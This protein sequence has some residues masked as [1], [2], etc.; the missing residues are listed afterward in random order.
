[1]EDRLSGHIDLYHN[2]NV[3]ERVTETVNGYGHG[4]EFQR[5]NTALKTLDGFNGIH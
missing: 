3:L 4:G 2:E 1:M 5:R